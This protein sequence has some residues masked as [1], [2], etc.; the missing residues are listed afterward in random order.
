MSLYC[1]VLPQFI[2]LIFYLW[3]TM[4]MP[5]FQCYKT[6]MNILNIHEDD[7]IF[8]FLRNFSWHGSANPEYEHVKSSVIYSQCS[9]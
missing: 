4:F 1:V 5:N 9:L 3:T 2:Y 7:N 8:D 6:L